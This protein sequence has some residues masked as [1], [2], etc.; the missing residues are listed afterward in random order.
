MKLLLAA[1][2]TVLAVATPAHAES[3]TCVYKG[4]WITT[5]TQNTDEMNWVLRWDK[6]KTGWNLTGLYADKY[7]KASFTGACANKSC[8][9]TQT[10]SSGSLKGKRY[11]YT[12]TYQDKALSATSTENT[13]HGT[14][15]TKSD[16]R[17]NGGVWESVAT[18]SVDAPKPAK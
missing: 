17:T 11:F 5:K 2:A 18:C 1:A 14:W 6:A 7:G 4:R 10:Y 15:G 16:N 9:M 13:F 12:G 8:D 3:W